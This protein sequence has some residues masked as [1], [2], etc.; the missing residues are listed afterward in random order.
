MVVE[1]HARLSYFAVAN[2][3]YTLV[4]SWILVVGWSARNNN[5]QLVKLVERGQILQ[6]YAYHEAPNDHRS[7]IALGATMAALGGCELGQLAIP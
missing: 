2:L 3:I 4:G 5:R 1:H 7:I 6:A